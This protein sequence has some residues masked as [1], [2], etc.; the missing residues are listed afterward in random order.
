MEGLEGDKGLIKACNEH[1]LVFT[2]KILLYS[3]TMIAP[4]IV[5]STL[6]ASYVPF[7]LIGCQLCDACHIVVWNAQCKTMRNLES[8]KPYKNRD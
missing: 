3:W 5:G 7:S 8:L 2:P 1:P 4:K 6:S